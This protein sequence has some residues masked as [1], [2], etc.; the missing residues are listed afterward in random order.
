MTERKAYIDAKDA[1]G[2]S[3]LSYAADSVAPCRV[4]T[5]LD[6]SADPF[7][8]NMRGSSLLNSLFHRLHPRN[9]SSSLHVITKLLERGC[10]P[11]F[12]DDDGQ[13]GLHILAKNVFIKQFDIF[14][15]TL[16]SFVDETERNAYM[17]IQDAMGKSA[18]SYAVECHSA[19]LKVPKLLDCLADPNLQDKDGQTPLHVLTKNQSSLR[20]R[21]EIV[22]MLLDCGADP[23]IPDDQGHLPVDY[24][25]DLPLDYM[26]DGK[27]FDATSAF[28]LLRR[29]GEAGCF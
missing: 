25:G 5:L 28:T 21:W 24:W 11:K 15:D 27:T 6:L 9:E 10:D 23:T 13:T 8:D 4:L 19:P 14:T 29:M 1:N 18:L 7:L 20:S 26:G 22:T 3:A 16:L 12:P 17:N 2:K